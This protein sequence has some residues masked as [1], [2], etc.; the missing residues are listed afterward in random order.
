MMG[1]LIL[2]QI[3]ERRGASPPLIQGRYGMGTA[4]TGGGTAEGEVPGCT[5]PCRPRN[6]EE[7]PGPAAHAEA[8]APA[9][10]V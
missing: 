9:P 5:L 7:H 2:Q 6:P 4:G 1:L 10:L 3:R 8:P